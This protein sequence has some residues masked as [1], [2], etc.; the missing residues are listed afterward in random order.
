MYSIENRIAESIRSPATDSVA[1][2]ILPTELPLCR[3]S[4]ER[5]AVSDMGILTCTTHLG[6]A[7]CP[8]IP[9]DVSPY[10]NLLRVRL[11]LPFDVDC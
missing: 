10:P 1:Q 9:E 8:F 3:P 5:H 7:D 2:S 11:A 4:L 6:A